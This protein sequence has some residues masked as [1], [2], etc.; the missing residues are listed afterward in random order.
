M[1]VFQLYLYPYCPPNYPASYPTSSPSIGTTYH[2][3]IN[4]VS[5]PNNPYSS[6]EPT[7]QAKKEKQKIDLIPMTYLQLYD[8]LLK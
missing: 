3:P 7:T 6:Q 8:E 1:S 4:N 2:F 5:F